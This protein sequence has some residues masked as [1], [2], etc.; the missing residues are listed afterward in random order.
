[1][2]DTWYKVMSDSP[3][4]TL[5]DLRECATAA[6]AARGAFARR[7]R[8]EYMVLA[9]MGRDFVERDFGDRPGFMSQLDWTVAELLCAGGWLRMES[10]RFVLGPRARRPLAGIQRIALPGVK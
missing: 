4:L 6:N 3:E 5:A 8:Q 1:M 9:W 10:G 2:A 7:G